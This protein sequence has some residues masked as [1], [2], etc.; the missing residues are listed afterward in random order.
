MYRLQKISKARQMHV[1]TSAVA[2]LSALSLSARATSKFIVEPWRNYLPEKRHKS[3]Q[4]SD[5]VGVKAGFHADLSPYQAV[6]LADRGPKQLPP[7]V[8]TASTPE[9]IEIT[10]S[11]RS[12]SPRNQ[13][14]ICDDWAIGQYWLTEERDNGRA[15][16]GCLTCG[17]C[18]IEHYASK[19]NSDLDEHRTNLVTILVAATVAHAQAHE[20]NSLPG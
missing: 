9:C 18:F 16:V 1:S 3:H 8:P 10:Q 13:D 17:I 19:I 15:V 6:P 5:P 7:Y 4:T 11:T 2:V 20:R 12:M 14:E